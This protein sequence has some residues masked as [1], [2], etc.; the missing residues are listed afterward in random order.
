[1]S[2]LLSHFQHFLSPRGYYL[3]YFSAIVQ[4][5]QPKMSV[6]EVNRALYKLFAAYLH[7]VPLSELIE[8]GNVHEGTHS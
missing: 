5:T 3:E 4:V 7:A 8:S 1:M 2:V 6:R